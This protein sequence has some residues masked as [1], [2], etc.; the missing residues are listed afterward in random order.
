MGN[1][2]VVGFWWRFLTFIIDLTAVLAI[3]FWLGLSGTDK[4]SLLLV[5]FLVSL[6]IINFIWYL[7]KGKNISQ[8]IC[9]IEILKEDSFEKLSKKELWKRY[10]YKFLDLYLPAIILTMLTIYIMIQVENNGAGMLLLV[11]LPAIAFIYFVLWFI[12]ILRTILDKEKRS[13]YDKKS[14]SILVRKNNN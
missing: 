12:S 6:Y 4:F 8:S 14:K 9:K 13:W 3:L 5:L 2:K 11:I 10:Y 1:Y 7:E